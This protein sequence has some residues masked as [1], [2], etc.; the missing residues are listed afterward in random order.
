MQPL[1]DQNAPV[2]QLRGFQ[3]F[4]RHAMKHSRFCTA[5]PTA[6]SF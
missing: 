2:R 6:F 1:E 5:S 3:T 4:G